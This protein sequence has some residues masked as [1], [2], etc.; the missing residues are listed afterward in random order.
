MRAQCNTT[1]TRARAGSTHWRAGPA[2]KRRNRDAGQAT[3]APCPTEP[4]SPGPSHPAGTAP[5]D[6]G[7]V[8]ERPPRAP[9]R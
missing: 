2:P 1:G 9:R 7:R 3:G 8:R 4:G 6:A 5:R